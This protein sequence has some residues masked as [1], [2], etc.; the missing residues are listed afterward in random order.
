RGSW[1]VG[2]DWRVRPNLTLSFGLRHEFQT[3]LDDK[4]NFAPRLGVA[5]SPFKSRKTTIRG[6]GGLFFERLRGGQY[7]NSIRFNGSTQRSYTIPNAVFNPNDPI[8]ANHLEANQDRLQL[9]SLTLRPLD[10]NLKAPYDINLSIG[11]EQQLPKGIVGSVTYM[12]SRG[13]HLFRT[14]NIN[15]P[16]S[17]SLEPDPD[18][19]KPARLMPNYP[20]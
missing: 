13:L 10:P 18:P 15:A 19:S 14:R 16:T 5:W 17:F 7:E 2:D 9:R 11:I 1:F 6:G 3:K 4:I 20:D 8:G 12:R